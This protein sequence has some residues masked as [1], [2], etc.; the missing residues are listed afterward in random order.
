MNLATELLYFAW[1]MCYAKNGDWG[2]GG[3]PE[4]FSNLDDPTC[5]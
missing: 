4:M 1:A 3:G 5:V 2:P